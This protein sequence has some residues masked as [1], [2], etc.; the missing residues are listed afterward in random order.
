MM[1]THNF[2]P[3]SNKLTEIHYVEYKPEGDVSQTLII[4]HG[5]GEHA[6][7]YQEFAEKLNAKGIS[8]FAL[9]F[10]GHGK[11]IGP[12]QKP[13]YF[14]ENGWDFLVEDFISLN[15]I[16][17]EKYPKI[18]CYVLGFSMGSFVIRTV[19]AERANELHSDGAILVSTSNLVPFAANFVKKMVALEAKKCG[20]ENVSKKVNDLA[21]GNYNKYFKPAK[22]DYD[23][24]CCNAE[25]LQDYIDDPMVNKVITPGMFMDLLSGMARTNGKNAIEKS[26]KIP[27][28]L[29]TGEEDP[30]GGFSKG[31]KKVAK[32]FMDTNPDVDLK[33]Y[34]NSRHDILHD[35]DKEVVMSDIYMWLKEH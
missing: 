18:P 30:V 3:S 14:G 22:T 21:F 17:K 33:V 10:I 19:M 23:W 15:K 25:G 7:R 27:V 4:A 13:M 34:P 35:N 12:N 32:V 2:F 26:K 11:S 28:L 29:L 24:L 1:T 16:V 6:G 20:P 9:D 8:V 31:V 5:I